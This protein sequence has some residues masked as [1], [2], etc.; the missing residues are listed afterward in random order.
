MANK[1]MY[2]VIPLSNLKFYSI[3]E[4]YPLVVNVCQWSILDSLNVD[5]FN[6]VNVYFELF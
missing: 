4:H 3:F 1:D 2:Y 5:E 6:V